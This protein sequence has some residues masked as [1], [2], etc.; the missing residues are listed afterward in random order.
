MKFGY[1][2]MY[3][4]GWAARRNSYLG[5]DITPAPHYAK[6][7]EAFGAY[8]EKI[9]KPGDIEVALKRGLEQLAQGK[10]ALLDVMVENLAPMMPMRQPDG[11]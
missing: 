5:V 2:I 6:V 3:P 10:A 7:A 8:G 11:S 1:Q 9:D 4:D